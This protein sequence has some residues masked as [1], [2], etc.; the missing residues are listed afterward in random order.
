MVTASRS[1][2]NKRSVS[3]MFRIA[4]FQMRLESLLDD[5]SSGGEMFPQPIVIEPQS[6]QERV[7][8]NPDQ[9]VVDLLFIYSLWLRVKVY[10]KPNFKQL[11]SCL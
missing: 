7:S 9:N 4:L 3:V 1:V 5:N 11:K 6:P 2:N 8:S 10:P